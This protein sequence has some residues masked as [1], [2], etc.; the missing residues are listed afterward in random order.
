MMFLPDLHVED[1]MV[2][3]KIISMQVV[4]CKSFHSSAYDVS[5]DANCTSDRRK[6]R[7]LVDVAMPKRPNFMHMQRLAAYMPHPSY[8][9]R[10]NKS[11]HVHAVLCRSLQ[12]GDPQ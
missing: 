3:Y 10:C 8:V 2:L 7:W 12:Q 11:V 9:N 4:Q 6:S 5:E 1:H